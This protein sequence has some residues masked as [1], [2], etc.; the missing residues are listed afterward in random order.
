MPTFSTNVLV[1]RPVGGKL[2]EISAI[3]DSAATDSVLPT[4]LIAELGIEA[5]SQVA[6]ARC[7]RD[8][9]NGLRAR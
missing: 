5:T 9:N 2:V 3:V 4:S 1:G 6:V 8:A 7:R